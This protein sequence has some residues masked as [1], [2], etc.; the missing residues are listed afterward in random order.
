MMRLRFV[1][2]VGSSVT[3]LRS[4]GSG[5]SAEVLRLHEVGVYRDQSMLL[6]NVNWTIR[7]SESWVVVGPNGGAPPVRGWRPGSLTGRSRARERGFFAARTGEEKPPR[8]RWGP[9]LTAQP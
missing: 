1:H 5:M 3:S 4:G 9:G 8:R 6:R 7:D 2:A